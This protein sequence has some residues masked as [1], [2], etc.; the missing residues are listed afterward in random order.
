MDLMTLPREVGESK[1][2][3]NKREEVFAKTKLQKLTRKEIM[4]E[5]LVKFWGWDI[6]VRKDG[7]R[8]EKMRAKLDEFMKELK[9][10]RQTVYWQLKED[11]PEEVVDKCY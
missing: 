10:K 11:L 2:E 8:K 9:Q 4:V 3:Y 6:E 1:D 5:L 7:E